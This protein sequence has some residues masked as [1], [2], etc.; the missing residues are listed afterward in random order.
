M[1]LLKDAIQEH[2]SVMITVLFTAAIVAQTETMVPQ[3]EATVPQL[4]T[5]VAQM[6][7]TVA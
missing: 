2:N 7:A 3:M 4:E 6:E 5:M 1:M